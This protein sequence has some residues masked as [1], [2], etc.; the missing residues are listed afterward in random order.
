MASSGGR[1]T[2][3]RFAAGIGAVAAGSLIVPSGVAH[4]DPDPSQEEV[5]DR[6]DEL[7]DEAGRLVDEYNQAKED[8]DA[9]KKKADELEDD[10]GDE[11]DRYEELQDKV[12]EFASAAYKSTELDATSTVLSVEEPDDL[13]DQSA[14][15]GY[16]SES[17]KKELDDFSESSE[18][19][20]K[21]KEEADSALEDAKDKK[22]EIEDKKDEVEDK[23]DEQESL[24]EEFPDADP[25]GEGDTEGGSYEGSASGDARTALDFAY[26]QIGKPYVYGGAG[27]DGY[28]CSGLTMRAWEAAGVDLPRTTYTQAE[29]GNRVS[30][31]QLQPGDLVFFD[32]LGHMGMYAGNDQMVHAPRTG[33]NVQV[34]SMAGHWDSKFQFGVRP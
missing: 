6:I 9:A 22:E 30:R 2:A 10:V 11:Q 29:V 7:N 16:L 1:R 23:I 18:R 25:A 21:L 5:E 27:P 8:Y 34:V 15:L 33:K 26:A 20:F 28:D 32:G 12:A 4:A 31:G 3:H 19:L 17:Q 13:L 24:L 14:D